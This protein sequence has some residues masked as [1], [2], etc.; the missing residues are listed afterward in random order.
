VPTRPRRRDSADRVENAWLMA[1]PPQSDSSHPTW[2][3]LARSL[4]HRP[5]RG[6]RSGC[7][8]CPCGWRG[9]AGPPHP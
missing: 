2:N 5:G 8:P 9:R 1:S 4:D 6:G 3:G 7:A